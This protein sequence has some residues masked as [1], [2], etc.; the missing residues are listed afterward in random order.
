MANPKGINQYTKSSGKISSLQKAR[1][2]VRSDL[3]KVS[4]KK[5]WVKA[6]KNM[7]AHDL[8]A[9]SIKGNRAGV[10]TSIRSFSKSK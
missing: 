10:L 8:N 3:N 9:L 1:A 4:V 5:P 2:Q 7:K 6:L